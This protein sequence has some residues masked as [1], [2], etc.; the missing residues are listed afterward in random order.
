[1]QKILLIIIFIFVPQFCFAALESSY[2]IPYCQRVHGQNNGKPIQIADGTYPD[3]ITDFTAIEVDFAKKYYECG[4]QAIH[5]A[6]QLN[7][8]PVCVLITETKNDCELYQRAKT[9]FGSMVR[10]IMLI[11]IGPMKCE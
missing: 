11:N 2:A 4:F 7:K 10:R 8:F 1:M 9:D 3:C 5:Y 6:N